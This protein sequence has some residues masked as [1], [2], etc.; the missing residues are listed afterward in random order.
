MTFSLVDDYLSNLPR[1]ERPEGI[2]YVTDLTKP[3]QR[4]AYLDIVFPKEY[5]VESQRVFESGRL[6]EDW[7]I[8]V[9]ERTSGIQ[10]LGQQLPARYVDGGLEIH[11]RVDAVCQH[12]NRTLVVH[13]VKSAK[14]TA[15]ISEPKEEHL[16]QLQ[17][18]LGCMG[19]DWGQVDYLDKR[20]ML[21]GDGV[22]VEKCF[23]VQ[24]DP[25]LFAA[26]V[27][28]GRVLAEAI[29]CGVAPV[30]CRGWL[31]DYCLHRDGECKF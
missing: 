3:C 30:E 20:V 7:W 9:L 17:F 2:L 31:C 12:D 16:L 23:T 24:R 5:P 26:V 6:I 19:L 15:Y 27:Q 10:V 18:Y 4:S 14:S 1:K 28:R 21:Q 13:E 25:G 8:H 29:R 22:S 11:G